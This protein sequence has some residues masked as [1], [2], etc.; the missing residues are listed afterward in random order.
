MTYEHFQDKLG[1]FNGTC[2]QTE[3]MRS[4]VGMG[5]SNGK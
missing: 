3:Y 2:S 5:T 4:F 1:S